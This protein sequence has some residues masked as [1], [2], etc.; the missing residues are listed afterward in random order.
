MKGYK[1]VIAGVALFP[2]TFTVAPAAVVTGILINKLNRYRPML[3]IG[4]TLATLGEGLMH[5]LDVHTSTPAWVFIALTAGLGLGI[6][7]PSMA[8]AVQAASKPADL[9]FAVAMFSFFRAFGQA[10]GV[11]IGGVIFQNQ[12]HAHLLTYPDLAPM[13]AAYS[14]D[15]AG[16]V[17]IINAMAE[18]L[19]KEQ[20]RQA[21]ADSL[22][23]VW[24]VMC[25]LAG[26]G[27]VANFAIRELTLFVR[28]E[29]AQGFLREDERRK[30]GDVEKTVV[31]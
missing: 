20:V 9:A 31:S 26:L 22:K 25:G 23:T 19:M 10:L 3:W 14:R 8:F 21:Y 4:W 17:Q 18:G 15:A 12:M 11:A 5:L 13:A 24:A 29:T 16:L 7:F 2:Q 30:R 6:L 1:P 28:Q 27:L